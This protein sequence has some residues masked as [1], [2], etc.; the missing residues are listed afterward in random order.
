VWWHTALAGRRW[1]ILILFSVLLGG[2]FTVSSRLCHAFSS[3][4]LTG[5]LLL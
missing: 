4:Q 5:R 2:I 1:Q 3:R